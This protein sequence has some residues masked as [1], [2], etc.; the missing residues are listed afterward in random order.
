MRVALHFILCPRIF[1]CGLLIALICASGWTVAAVAPTRNA[2]RNRICI[3]KPR[4]CFANFVMAV[5]T[6]RDGQTI[7]LRPGKYFREVAVLRANN[8][9][10]RST[11]GLNEYA[12]F[13]SQGRVAENKA[14][15]V[16]RGENTLIDGLAFVG[17]RAPHHN[18]AG[19]RH[20][21]GNLRIRNSKFSRNEMGVLSGARNQDEIEIIDSVFEASE[22]PQDKNIPISQFPAHNIYIG[23]IAKLTMRGV[24]SH[25][26]EIGHTLKSRANIND[27]EANYFSTRNGT[28]SYEAEF[29]SGGTVRFV[30]NIV[31]QGHGSENTTMFG[32]AAEY[33]RYPNPG[34]HRV[35]LLQNTFVNHNRLLGTMVKLFPAAE[36][37]PT[38]EASANIWIGPGKPSDSDNQ[39][40]RGNDVVEFDACDFRPIV[41]VALASKI[42]AAQYEYVHPARH[43]LRKAAIA[44]ALSPDN[45]TLRGC[46]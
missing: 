20:E 12:T 19:I 30:G 11:G 13:D 16:I 17:A 36:I 28:G 39:G 44:G 10:I 46:S 37:S 26:V 45:A 32:F 18:G 27:I 15:L 40:L 34:P 42:P 41:S 25:S 29:P 9:T 35:I 2:D 43:R 5:S 23:N 1:M 38:F 7:E 22:R 3:V 4:Q 21:K 24:W 14:I 33:T 6:V 8:V 31:E